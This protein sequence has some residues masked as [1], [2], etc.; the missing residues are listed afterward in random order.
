MD[1]ILIKSVIDKSATHD[2]NIK[3][4]Q[5][6]VKKMSGQPEEIALIKKDMTQLSELL[7]DIKFPVGEMRDLSIKISG[8]DTRLNQPVK[9]IV[10]HQHHFPKILWLSIGLIIS[11]A[12]V[13]TGWYMTGSALQEYKASD[14]K[15]RYLKLTDHQPLQ[16]LLSITDSLYRSKANMRDSV[17]QQEEQNKRKLEMLQ[18]AMK[19]EAEAKELK[20]KADA[21]K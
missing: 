9:N 21:K 15:Y 18:R 3:A 1:D 2:N 12:V 7:K 13:C 5:E 10:Q 8:L 14:T 20:R 4:L 19:L 11:M 16:E 17:L 6:A